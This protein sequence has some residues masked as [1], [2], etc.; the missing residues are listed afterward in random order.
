MGVVIEGKGGGSERDMDCG[1]PWGD[2]QR[3]TRMQ[4]PRTLVTIKTDAIII[5]LNTNLSL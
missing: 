2:W 5:L 4:R 1:L 3:G